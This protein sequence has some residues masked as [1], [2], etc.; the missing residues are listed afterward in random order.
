MLQRA[1][2]FHSLALA[3]WCVGFS[4]TWW[5]WWGG[6]LNWH[7]YVCMF[8]SRNRAMDKEGGICATQEHLHHCREMTGYIQ[9]G[10]PC[11]VAWLTLRPQSQWGYTQIS[12]LG[13]TTTYMCSLKEV[14]WIEQ[15]QSMIITQNKSFQ[16]NQLITGYLDRNHCFFMIK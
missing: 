7:S 4:V 9:E 11:R 16:N 1:I 13:C 12:T 5:P 14:R 8:L 10:L 3:E 6:V 2:V 15:P